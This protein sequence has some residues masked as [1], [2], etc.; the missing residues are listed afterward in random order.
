VAAGRTTGLVITRQHDVHVCDVNPQVTHVQHG[1]DDGKSDTTLA[2]MLGEEGLAPA[3]AAEHW[4]TSS[5]TRRI[6]RL[7]ANRLGG[8][9]DLEGTGRRQIAEV[10]NSA[11][12]TG[13][14]VTSAEVNAAGVAAGALSTFMAQRILA[15]WRK[16]PKTMSVVL[17][18]SSVEEHVSTQAR[19]DVL[20]EM[21]R[22][23][24]FAVEFHRWRDDWLARRPT[25]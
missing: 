21:Q 4:V 12:D 14:E 25:T 7:Y 17:G 5:V 22:C 20:W 3:D 2:A 23:N 13:R 8:N 11:I 16:Y 19:D 18:S 10:R 24:A 1:P 15:N 6:K 9:W